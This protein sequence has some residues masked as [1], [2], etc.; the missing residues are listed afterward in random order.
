MQKKKSPGRPTSGPQPKCCSRLPP[1]PS[2]HPGFNPPVT[3]LRPVYHS[4]WVPRPYHV[5]LS[6]CFL[7]TRGKQQRW[8]LYKSWASSYQSSGIH[9]SGQQWWKVLLMVT[10]C[11]GWGQEDRRTACLGE[12]APGGGWDR[13][14]WGMLHC[15]GLGEA[16]LG[17]QSA[18]WSIYSS[19]H[20]ITRLVLY[21]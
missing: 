19:T 16:H 1:F 5:R 11:C 14:G 4:P 6:G 2:R 10:L 20:K 3:W 12:A 15:Q 8:E 13:E 7:T 9:C 21:L 17:A 18:L